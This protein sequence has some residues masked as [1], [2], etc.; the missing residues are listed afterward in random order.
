MFKQILLPLVAVS[1]S[2]MMA[3]CF[4]G[5]GVDVKINPKALEDKDEVQKIYDV[6]LKA[7][8]DQATKAYEIT[9]NIDN[10]ADKG[11]EGDAYLLLMIEVQDPDNK[12]QLIRHMFH[13]EA[14]G[15]QQTQE[16]T[17]DVRGS[18]EEKANFRLENELFD[19]KNK[20]SAE[21]FHKII[22]DAYEKENK[23]PENYVY[24]YVENVRINME[25]Y[26]ISIN[27]KLKSNDQLIDKIYHYDL[28][29]NPVD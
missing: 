15:W 27:G 17:V 28:D 25:G 24:R 9:I 3:G 4:G 21:K 23:E 22:L 7:M 13:G 1:M 11:G 20:V 29:G 6:I 2:V 12:K 26:S 14:G 16:L 8:G 5:A 18:D 19:F 10:P